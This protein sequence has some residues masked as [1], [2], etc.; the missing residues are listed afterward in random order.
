MGYDAPG[1]FEYVQSINRYLTTK[2]R[3]C[4]DTVLYFRKMSKIPLKMYI[5]TIIAIELES[6]TWTHNNFIN[7]GS[8]DAIIASNE[9]WMSKLLIVNIMTSN[10]PGL[11]K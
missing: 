7:P 8:F 3:P 11:K 1:I 9:I 5:V 4:V 10:L 2:I 6:H